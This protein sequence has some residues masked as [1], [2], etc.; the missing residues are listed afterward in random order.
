M[1]ISKKKYWAWPLTVA[2]SMKVG[3]CDACLVIY[4]RDCKPII[5]WS[6]CLRSEVN[7]RPIQTLK[8]KTKKKSEYQIIY[9][10]A[11]FI[12]IEFCSPV[13]PLSPPFLRSIWKARRSLFWRRR[14]KTI[15][16][17]Q[18]NRQLSFM[19][20]L[21]QLNTLQHLAKPYKHNHFSIYNRGTY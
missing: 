13:H 21:W 11:T 7:R 9:I 17:S 2:L 20:S 4:L 14:K 8:L 18:P 6:M 15:Q 19:C 3:N 12:L 5:S 1:F 16:Q 10:F